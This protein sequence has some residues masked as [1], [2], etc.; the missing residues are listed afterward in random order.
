MENLDHSNERIAAIN[1]AKENRPGSLYYYEHANQRYPQL[2]LDESVRH[3]KCAR[4]R[5][6][7]CLHLTRFN[8]HN[9]QL[10]CLKYLVSNML[11][12]LFTVTRLQCVRNVEKRTVCYLVIAR[13]TDC[14]SIRSRHVIFRNNKREASPYCRLL[15]RMPPPRHP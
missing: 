13:S 2:S 9:L 6:N 11:Q 12:F 5:L 7:F 1:I 15:P 8:K 10:L 14:E 3:Q 4:L